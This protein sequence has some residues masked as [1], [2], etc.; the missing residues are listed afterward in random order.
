[1]T[2]PSNILR[3]SATRDQIQITGQFDGGK[4]RLVELPLN[5]GATNLAALPVLLEASARGV[6]DFRVARFDGVRDRIYSSFLLVIPLG[7][8]QFTVLST[9]RFVEDFQAAAKYRDAFPNVASKKGLQVQMEDDAIALGVKH[10]ALNVDF[11]GM[12]DF[13]NRSNSIP[14]Q[15]DG[16]TIHFQ[17]N[18]VEA[19][20]RRVK[21]LSDAGVVISFILLNYDTGNAAA[22]KILLHPD[23]DKTSP[24]HLSAFNTVTDEGLF[25]FKAWLEFLA[26]RYSQPGYPH[27][28][29][30]NF[31]LGN[32]VNSHW[33]WCNLGRVPM[34][35]FA[36]DYLRAMRVAN[37]ALR[38]YSS[39]ARLY[40]S[41]EHHWNIAYPGGNDRQTFPARRFIDYFNQCAKM[42][43]DFDWNL[44]YHPYP[45][46]LFEPR[47]W[48]DKSARMDDQTPRIN[49]KNLE[50]LPRYFRRPELLYQGQPRHII[51]SEQGFHSAPTPEGERLQAAGYAYAFYR[52]ARIEGIDSFILHRH[53]DHPHEGGLNLGLWR[54]NPATGQLEKKPI[55]EVF[56]LADTL[57][58]EKAFDF[59]LPII[60]I[61]RWE[62]LLPAQ[63]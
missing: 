48:N 62:E 61:H 39:C 6:K 30:V 35:T 43:G 11:G 2:A 17:R 5:Q 32:E 53:V 60:G 7:R 22:N 34:E 55:Y 45:E 33:F 56:R 58:W 29:V 44:A 63:R 25:Y 51:L 3:V 23:F 38:K 1:M 41:L 8:N 26:D 19:L 57:D 37:T 59:A 24:N 52:S 15:L 10:A 31:I 12:V 20:D 9:N 50:L 4:F 14:W 49:F 18:A 54:K 27:G 46:N 47:T 21:T 36:R 42:E 13:A 40:M 28:R 16:R